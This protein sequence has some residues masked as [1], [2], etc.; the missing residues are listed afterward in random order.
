MAPDR[1][2]AVFR[3]YRA[4]FERGEHPDPRPYVEAAGGDAERLRA[5]IDDFLVRAQPPEPSPELVA[6]FAAWLTGESPLLEL[7]RARGVSRESVVRALAEALEV[8]PSQ[9][10]KLWDYYICMETGL[11]EVPRIDRRVFAALTE[12]LGAQA[13]EVPLSRG[14]VVPWLVAARAARAARADLPR[15][16]RRRLRM[17]DEVD[18][19]FLGEDRRLGPRGDRENDR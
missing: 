18:A 7:R 10:V 9:R 5:L 15:V 3:D 2:L 13:T 14:W 19:L 11:L 16:G 12:V 17:R 6:A 1:T 8:D 4:R